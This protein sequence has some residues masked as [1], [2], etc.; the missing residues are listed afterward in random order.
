MAQITPLKFLYPRTV[1][2]FLSIH[3]A[4]HNYRVLLDNGGRFV[5]LIVPGVV[6]YPIGNTTFTIHRKRLSYDGEMHTVYADAIG[7][8]FVASAIDDLEGSGVLEYIGIP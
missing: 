4:T 8:A 5:E 2:R 6:V 1:F 7:W 3:I